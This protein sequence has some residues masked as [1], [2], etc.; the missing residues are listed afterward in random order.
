MSLALEHTFCDLGSEGFHLS[1]WI[2]SKNSTRYL[3][4]SHRRVQLLLLLLRILALLVALVGHFADT[5]DVR[6]YDYGGLDSTHLL[7][8]SGGEKMSF[9]VLFLAILPLLVCV[10][11]IRQQIQHVIALFL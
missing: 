4:P 2:Q 10:V 3:W 6:K 5:R 9:C 1:F 8:G 7:L 11:P